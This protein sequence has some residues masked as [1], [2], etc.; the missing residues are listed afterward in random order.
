MGGLLAL[1]VVL[2]MSWFAIFALPVLELV[3]VVLWVLGRR[4]RAREV[5]TG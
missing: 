1:A 4:R 3:A 2:G 5:A